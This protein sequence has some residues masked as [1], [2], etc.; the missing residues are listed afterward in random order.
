MSA[1]SAALAIFYFRVLPA[2]LEARGEI[3]RLSV[4][5][6]YQLPARTEFP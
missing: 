6:G 4:V 3:G 2:R 1:M 5:S